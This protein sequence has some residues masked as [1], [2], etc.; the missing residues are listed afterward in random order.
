M[1][2]REL[3]NALEDIIDTERELREQIEK[4]NVALRCNAIISSM[5]SDELKRQ[6]QIVDNIEIGEFDQE[7]NIPT[8]SQKELEER[9]KMR[10]SLD[11]SIGVSIESPKLTKDELE[12]RAKE[13]ENNSFQIRDDFESVKLSDE[14]LKRREAE[15]NSL[16]LSIGNDFESQQ[17]SPEELKKRQAE[18]EKDYSIGDD[19][20]S[21]QLSPEELKRRKSEREAIDDI[22]D[23]E[24]GFETEKLSKE[25]IESRQAEREKLIKS[26]GKIS[27]SD[28]EGTPI[29]VTNKKV[30][31]KLGKDKDED[32]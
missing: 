27:D 32:K 4:L 17:L 30:F 16:D 24:E 9:K 19:F 7:L 12:K 3:V 1:N 28:D 8:L 23:K 5:G 13:R 26:L 14:E 6:E 31:P 20:E 2:N 29:E 10:E 22:F 21:Q 25:E 15:R 18:R 11:F